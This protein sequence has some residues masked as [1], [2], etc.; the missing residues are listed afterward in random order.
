MLNFLLILI[1]IGFAIIFLIVNVAFGFIRVL[2]SPFLGRRREQPSYRRQE[3]AYTYS[4]E[5]K[6]RSPH[7]GN[8]EKVI[9]EDEGEYVDFEEIKEDK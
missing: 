4:Q 2:L 3:H 9:G 5:E 1:I 6:V 8:H 7:T